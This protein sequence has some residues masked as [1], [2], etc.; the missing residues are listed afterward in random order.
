MIFGKKNRKKNDP[1]VR[2]E[3]I[4]RLMANYDDSIDPEEV[5]STFMPRRRARRIGS[6]LLRM[7]RLILMIL[8]A[9]ALVLAIFIL[10][11]T[12]EKMGNFTINLNRL[13]L[14]RRGISISSDGDFTEPT[15][16]L[17]ASSLQDASNTTLED[18]PENLDELD[19]DHNGRNYVAY[20]YYVRNAGKET[21]KYKATVNLESSTKGAEEAARVAVYK[22]GERTIYAA[23]TK[24][25]TA[26]KGCEQFLDGKVVCEYNEEAFEVG[27]VDKYTVV[28]WLEGEDPECVDAIVGG[29][30]QFSMNLDAMEDSNTPLVVKYVQ[31][32]KDT[33]T[34]KKGIWSSGESAPDYYNDGDITW[35]NR[36]NQ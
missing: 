9:A 28:I 35:E 27:N 26:E 32:L 24:E 10:A 7:D 36:K 31:D 34:G 6:A 12:Q 17:T 33:F 4:E 19:G 2:V 8:L 15:A 11:F 3:D 23:P 30:V 13:E 1:I 25:G 22:N 29:S 21:L 18:L 16:R 14:Y 20:T 5:I